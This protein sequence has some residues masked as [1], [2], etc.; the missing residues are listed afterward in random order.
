MRLT[1]PRMGQIDIPVRTLFEE[2]GHQVVPP[3][4][5][6]K[7]TFALAVKYAPE[8]ACLPFKMTLANYIEAM[9]KGPAV[10]T[11]G[12]GTMPVRLLCPGAR[13]LIWGMILTCSSWTRPA[14][15]PGN[16]S[17]PSAFFSGR[18]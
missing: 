13:D 1:F 9:E 5:V 14:P 16:S 8:F 11:F 2:L 4:P 12:G 17:G 6:T 15:K 3:P 7:R 18:T 10:V